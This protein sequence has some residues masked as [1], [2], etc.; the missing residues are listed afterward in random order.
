VAPGAADPYV[1]E[2]VRDALASDD[3][4]ATLEIDVYVDGT[5]V[6]V[7]G[8]VLT[9]E[10]REAIGVVVAELLPDHRVRNEIAVRTVVADHDAERLS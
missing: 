10:R 7:T 1:V 5:D 2:R 9:D 6:Y 4:T 3:R 8:T